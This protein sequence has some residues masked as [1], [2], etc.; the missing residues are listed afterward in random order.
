MF[1]CLCVILSCWMAWE[2][3][4]GGFYAP[5]GLLVLVMSVY[6]LCTYI[7]LKRHPQ[8]K[9]E[10]RIL[11][12]EQQQ[13]SSSESNNHCHP[14]PCGAS[15]PAGDCPPFATGV[16]VLAN[17]HSFKSQLRATA[18]TLFL[19]LATWALGGLAVS[20]GH[21]LDMIFSCLYG[22]FCVTLGLFLLIQHCA[23]RDDVWHRWWACCPSKSKMEDSNGAGQSQRQGL[24]QPHCHLNSPCSGKQPLLSPHLVQSSYHK[25][26]P[27][28]QSPSTEHAGPC[29][30][31]VLSPVSSAPISPLAEPMPSPR[32]QSLPDE[33]PRPILPLQSC[34]S[35]RTKSRSFNRPRPCLQDYRS[36]MASTSMDGSVHS[37]HLD[38]PHVT[39]HLEGSPLVSNSPHPDIQLPCLSPHLDKQLASCHSLQRQT[40]CHSVQDSMASCH[41]HAHN[42]H[43]SI[44]SC[45]SLLLPSHGIHTCQ[46]HMYSSAD[47]SSTTSCCEKPDP[48]ALQYQQ[49]SDAYSCVSK[50]TDKDKDNLCEEAEQKGFPRNTLPRRHAAVNLRGTISRNRSLQ[51]DSLYGS[52][53]ARNIR[54]GPW[55]NETTV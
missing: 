42:M 40:S 49:D 25:M 54:T 6:F 23:K 48:F 8:R 53:A 18:F 11:N 1:L 4:L 22:A 7:Q 33:L 2:P 10:L 28:P 44:S 41:S 52:D 37:S 20:L 47:H 45:H 30:V 21:F 26:T 39:H 55:R 51:E 16:S 3:S 43:D 35:D 50:T 31:A 34:L 15:G 17:E 19:F 13:L 46:W 9:Y 14:D 38:S 29:C 24:H 5:M 12:E 27:P 32:P 36:H